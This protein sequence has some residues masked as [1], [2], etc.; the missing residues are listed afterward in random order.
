M[1]L[2]SI[3]VA[4]SLTFFATTSSA[5]GCY[6]S[7]ILSPSPFL[8]NDGEIFKLAD[9]SFWEVKY[10]YEYLYA[11]SPEVIICPSKGKLSVETKTLNVKRVASTST[12]PSIPA[13][14]ANGKEQ[15][16]VA[17]DSVIESRIDG[18]FNG[19][20][21]ETIFKLA[22]G[23]IWQQSAYAYKYHYAYRPEVIIFP[24]E[25]RY[26]MKVNGV[27]GAIAVQRLR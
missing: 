26:K 1:K 2:L 4:L 10:E 6:E 3:I 21:G 23:Q 24:S 13:K 27:D 17:P 22:N 25:G 20:E 7:V 14:A 11:Y 19:W 8:G 18:T 12:P 5:H 15:N 16:Q 9:G